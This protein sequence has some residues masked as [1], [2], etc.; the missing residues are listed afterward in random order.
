[1]GQIRT[2]FF[3]FMQVDMLDRRLGKIGVP[4]DEQAQAVRQSVRHIDL[5]GAHKRH[6]R[7]AHLPGCPGGVDSLQVAGDRKQNAGN[8]LRLE[9]GV[10]LEN[11]LQ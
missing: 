5:A 7:P 6:F 9:G 4:M 2:Q 3:G 1:M 10:G 8:I 11:G